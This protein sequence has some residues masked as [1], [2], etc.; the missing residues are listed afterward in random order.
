MQEAFGQTKGIKLMAI[1]T[2]IVLI[3]LI[4]GLLFG[5][6]LMHFMHWKVF[7]AIIAV[8]GFIL[9]VGLLLAMLETVKRGA[10]LFSAKSVLRDF[11]N[12]FCNWLFFFGAATIFLS[13]ILMMSWVAVLLV[14]FIDAGSLTTLQFAW[15]QVLVFGAVIV[16]NAIV[17]RFVKDLTELRFIWR[18][19]LI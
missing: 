5:A 17:A 16:A 3:A 10:V 8:M 4:I 1:I 15:T 12:V 7:F 11:C 18:A 9:F 2:F 14:I 6:A 13:Y 19:V